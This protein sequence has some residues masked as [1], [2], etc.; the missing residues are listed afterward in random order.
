M[1]YRYRTP[2]SQEY[3]STFV[4]LP[5]DYLNQ[6]L[7][8]RQKEYD[9]N[10]LAINEAED[11]Y[12]SLESAPQWNA[13]K[14]RLLDETFGNIHKTI[15]DKYGGDYSQGTAEIMSS[16][17]GLR[18][19][20]FWNLMA[21]DTVDWKQKKALY[22]QLETSGQLGYAE[23]MDDIPVTFQ[24]GTWSAPKRKVYAKVDTNAILRNDFNGLFNAV[25]EENVESDRPGQFKK[26]KR[27]GSTESEIRAVITDSY[28]QDLLQKNPQLAYMYPDAQ[29]PAVFREK[30]IKDA[31][32]QM[33]QNET[34]DYDA[35]Q[36]QMT[37]YQRQSLALQ[38]KNMELDY[39]SQLAKIQAEGKSGQG[40]SF[41]MMRQ[42][43]ERMMSTDWKEFKKSG[44]ASITDIYDKDI[45]IAAQR[46]GLPISTM[47]EFNELLSN[48]DDPRFQS[49]EAFE[50][51]KAAE[52]AKIKKRQD[53]IKKRK[54]TSASAGYSVSSV[55]TPEME[56]QN[57]LDKK[58]KAID[59][60]VRKV[61]DEKKPDALIHY[62][63]A[64]TAFSKSSDMDLVKKTK[65][66][67]ED[68]VFSGFDQ[69]WTILGE[70]REKSND[71]MTNTLPKVTIDKEATTYA[72]TRDG[73]AIV[74][75]KYKDENGKNFS[76]QFV[77]KPEASGINRQLVDKL[78]NSNQ[79]FHNARAERF[80]K[81]TDETLF[82]ELER[83]ATKE[84]MTNRDVFVKHY[85]NIQIDDILKGRSPDELSEN[86]L[87]E[88]RKITNSF[89]P[90]SL[91][92]YYEY[93]HTWK[94]KRRK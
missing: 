92:K 81:F 94:N 25:R 73:K 9:Q 23:G 70:G 10:L 45:A 57:R 31:M 42:A 49:S 66:Y 83:R 13:E 43:G 77:T 29:N 28:V 6:A 47:Q 93:Y 1:A 27:V 26:I 46:E 34:V 84:D 53:E 8:S 50:K 2:R 22:D 75:V 59:S 90:E 51:Y 87:K 79:T 41:D 21:Q 82:P 15:K 80:K 76:R 52:I 37:E 19:K 40:G 11:R 30:L 63:F 64:P 17:V 62:N 33:P 58:L 54:S 72:Q 12:A 88:I 69:N 67:V 38:R 44:E 32:G 55:T 39:A 86:E 74:E 18:K 36:N 60:D 85:M 78:D 4:P 7:Q 65:G 5:M 24:N 89:D 71:W 35:D 48:K 61:Y 16:I 3:L 56:F 20:P 68:L 14:T 91:E